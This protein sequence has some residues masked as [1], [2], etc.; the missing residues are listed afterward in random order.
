MI[1]NNRKDQHQWYYT[2]VCSG[3]LPSLLPLS[4]IDRACSIREQA[5]SSDVRLF[6]SDKYYEDYSKPVFQPGLKV[7]VEVISFGP[8]GASVNVVAEGHSADALPPEDEEWPVLAEGLINQKELAYYRDARDNVEVVLGEILPAYVERIRDV[9]DK[10]GIGLRA[11]GGRAKA[12]DLG[13]Q[14]M[15]ALKASTD[16]TLGLGDKSSPAAIAAHFPG[17][18]KATFKKALS[19]LFKQGLIERPGATETQLIK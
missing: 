6:S 18:S 11:F 17:T 4:G 13:G 1:P 12:A 19:A 2:K 8:I 16:G 15:E 3:S 14:I 7:L 9:D 10:L 5:A